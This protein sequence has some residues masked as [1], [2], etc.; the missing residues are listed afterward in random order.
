MGFY[1]LGFFSYVS[2]CPV[3]MFALAVMLSTEPYL[4]AMP[5]SRYLD[6]HLHVRSCLDTLR[7]TKTVAPS[8]GPQSRAGAAMQLLCLA[9]LGAFVVDTPGLARHTT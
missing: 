4:S 5:G 3:C 8:V 1:E 9:T 6:A 2:K 7:K